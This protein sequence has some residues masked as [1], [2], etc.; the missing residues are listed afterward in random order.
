MGNIGVGTWSPFLERLL[1]LYV[2]I[3]R[4]SKVHDLHFNLRDYQKI[5]QG[6][7]SVEIIIIEAFDPDQSFD[8]NGFRWARA[9]A[10]GQGPKP[11][12]IFRT[13]T[14]KPFLKSPHFIDFSYLSALA[15]KLEQLRSM[16]QSHVDDFE[17]L[18]AAWP[19]LMIE[20]KH[21]SRI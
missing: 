14:L 4:G 7:Q 1:V 21:R 20:P 12:V 2:R 8:A 11:L 10:Q 6:S 9:L 15:T 18:A 3:V 5:Y 17:R 16:K 19:E 13:I